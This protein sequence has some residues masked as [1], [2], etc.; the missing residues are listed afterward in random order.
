MVCEYQGNKYLSFPKKD[1]SILNISD[2]G[3]VSEEDVSEYDD[4][5]TIHGAEVIG[6]IFADVP[7]MCNV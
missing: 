1:A 3:G 2:I 7:G 5:F 6:V 4:D